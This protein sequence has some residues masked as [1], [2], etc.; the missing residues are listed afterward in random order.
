MALVINVMDRHTPG[1]EMRHQL[2]PKKTKAV[3]AIYIAIKDILL[4]LHY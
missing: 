2:Q 3:L 4:A 1:N